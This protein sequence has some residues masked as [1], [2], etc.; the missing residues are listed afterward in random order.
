MARPPIATREI[1]FLAG[2]T[3]AAT[4]VMLYLLGASHEDA[5]HV[6][7]IPSATG[8]TLSWRGTF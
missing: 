3:L 6:A 7:M 1:L 4:G 5:E 2:G 8:G